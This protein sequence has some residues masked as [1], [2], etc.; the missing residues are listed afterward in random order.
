MSF[1]ADPSVF[2]F[3]IYLR[4]H[5]LLI[6]QCIANSAKDGGGS[7][8]AARSESVLPFIYISQIKLP[9]IGDFE[10]RIILAKKCNFIVVFL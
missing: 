6:R 8:M 7:L 9:D 2:N 4:T 3:Y 1:T 10:F 5:P